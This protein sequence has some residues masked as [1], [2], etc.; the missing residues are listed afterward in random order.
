[1]QQCYSVVSR[2]MTGIR[3]SRAAQPLLE[4]VVGVG[5]VVERGYLGVS[6]GAVHRDG[7]DERPVGLE[8]DLAYAMVGGAALELG[9]QAPADAEP[10]RR[11]GDPH[12]LDLGGRAAVELQR[13]AADRLAAEARDEDQACRQTQLVVLGG[14]R[15]R[16]VEPGVEPDATTH[17]PFDGGLDLDAAK[18]QIS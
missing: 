12:A 14:D 4:P 2:R 18:R 13:A 6:R 10:A 7:L 8:P 11:C 17:K 9:E 16:R 3:P 15:A 5:L 1:M